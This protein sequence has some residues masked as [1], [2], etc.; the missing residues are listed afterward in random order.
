M[1]AV[2]RREPDVFTPTWL[3]SLCGGLLWGWLSDFDP[4]AHPEAFYYGLGG[5]S[6]LFAILMSWA[7]RRVRI[8]RHDRAG[9]KI[10]SDLLEELEI[11]A[12]EEAKRRASD[13]P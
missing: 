1:R 6:L 5:S 13:E 8:I 7:A 4:S 10:L 11:A 2:R 12:Q 9:R 3:L